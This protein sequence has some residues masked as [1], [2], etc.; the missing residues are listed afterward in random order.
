MA[1]DHANLHIK[2]HAAKW[3]AENS[4]DKTHKMIFVHDTTMKDGKNL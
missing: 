1:T 2:V 3:M 4:K